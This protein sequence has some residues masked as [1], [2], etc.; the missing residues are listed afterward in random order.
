[1]SNIL[2]RE[3]ILNIQDLKTEEVEVPEWGGAVLVRAL[4]GA[5]RDQFEATVVETKGKN[6]RVNL[7]N[8]RAK[9]VAMSVV[10][11]EGNKL[12]TPADVAALGKKS[13]A[14]LARIFDVA[15]RLAGI[16]EKDIEGDDRRS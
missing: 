2:N 4:T 9:L 15:M 5:E 13:A 16:S 6:T 7:V 12:F 3:A 10:D 11:E 1:M 14:A 8:A